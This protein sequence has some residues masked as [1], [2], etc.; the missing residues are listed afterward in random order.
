MSSIHRFC[1]VFGLCLLALLTAG[2]GCDVLEEPP[3]PPEVELTPADLGALEA[4]AGCDVT[5]SKLGVILSGTIGEGNCPFES[6]NVN[7]VWGDPEEGARAQFAGFRIDERA[8]VRITMVS[9]EIDSFLAL[10]LKTGAR[11]GTG[12]DNGGGVNARIETTLDPGTYL[13]AA[14]AT[15]SEEEGAL[16]LTIERVALP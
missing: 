7:S 4:L 2:T 13:I 3:P 6:V 1:P 9:D 8:R 14:S 12:A 16:Q 10:W 5:P 15:R 11:R